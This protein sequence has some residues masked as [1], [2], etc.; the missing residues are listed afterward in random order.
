MPGNFIDTNVLVYLA[1]QE[2]AKVARA[3]SLLATGDAVISVQVL[4]ELATVA[5]R[6]MRLAWAE[7]DVFL[8]T[9]RDLLPVRP[10]TLAVHD[11]GLEIARRHRLAVYDAMIV[12]SALDAG[13]DVLYSEDMQHG[14]CFAAQLRL[15]NPFLD[16]A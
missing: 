11:T 13:C 3:E 16:T 1:S 4:N 7:L 9:I 6:K 8:E 10:L 12:A 15:V 5:R 14:Q 2:D